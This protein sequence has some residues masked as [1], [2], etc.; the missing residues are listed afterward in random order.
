MTL[1]IDYQVLR[2]AWPA[3]VPLGMWIC[4]FPVI[5][6]WGKAEKRKLV[7]IFLWALSV[8]LTQ[9]AWALWIMYDLSRHAI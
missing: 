9:A 3:L 2:V 6:L 8:F 1:G 7:K 5:V 4:C